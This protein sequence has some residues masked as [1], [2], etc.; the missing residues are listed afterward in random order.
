MV[1]FNRHLIQAVN[2]QKQ[3]FIHLPV[4][5]VGEGIIAAESNQRA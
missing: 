3:Y 4:Y 2:K 1:I 5:V